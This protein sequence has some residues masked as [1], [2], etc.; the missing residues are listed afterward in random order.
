LSWD[1]AVDAFIL[2]SR[3]TVLTRTTYRRLLRQAGELLCDVSMGE[4]TAE[5]LSAL[6]AA[7]LAS[8]RR[9]RQQMLT[10]AQIELAARGC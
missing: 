4:L 1:A 3:Y 2:V 6:R 5:H 10:A 7:V 9:A 8:Q